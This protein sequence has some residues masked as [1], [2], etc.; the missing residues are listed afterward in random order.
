M[1]LVKILNVQLNVLQQVDAQHYILI[2]KMDIVN[3]VLLIVIVKMVLTVL[4]M[5][6]LVNNLFAL[7]ILI[8]KIMIMVDFVLMEFA[9][10]VRIQNNVDKYTRQIIIMINIFV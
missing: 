1:K 4:I 5:Y 9:V 8:V 7:L 10:L 3:S 2:V 6:A